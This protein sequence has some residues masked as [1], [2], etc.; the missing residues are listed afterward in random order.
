M[1]LAF[2]DKDEQF[3]QIIDTLVS[4]NGDSQKVLSTIVATLY[5][6]TEKYP[7]ICYGLR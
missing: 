3:D 6:F 5:A 1:D 7:N 2:R 4:N